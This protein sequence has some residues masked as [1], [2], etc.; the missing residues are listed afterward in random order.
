M[1]SWSGS[2]EL[3]R[4]FSVGR[5]AAVYIM[6]KTKTNQQSVRFVLASQCSVGL[7]IYTLLIAKLS[8]SELFVVRYTN[9]EV[10]AAPID[11]AAELK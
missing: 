5:L 6:Y 8:R 4:D 9:G 7:Y 2:V 3:A 10:R 1:R 11:R